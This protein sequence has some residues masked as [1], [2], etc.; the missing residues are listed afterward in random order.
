M[1]TESYETS[2]KKIKDLN[3]WRDIPCSWIGKLYIVKIAIFLIKHS[4]IPIKIPAVCF[5]DYKIHVELQGTSNKQSDLEKE[6]SWGIHI[7]NSKPS[8][9]NQAVIRQCGTGIT[10]MQ[11]QKIK[12]YIYGQ[13]F[14]NNGAKTII[15]KQVFSTGLGQ[16]DIHKPKNK[17]GVLQYTI[18]KNGSKT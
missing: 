3:K 18:C 10:T 1:Y 6:Q 2:V 4:T 13:S 16:L 14:L 7:S 11:V 8:Y 9:S 17:A 12:C 15:G 5:V